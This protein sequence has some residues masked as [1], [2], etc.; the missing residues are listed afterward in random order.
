MSS[1]PLFRCP[2]ECGGTTK[3]EDYCPSC[4]RGT[5]EIEVVVA[6]DA[7]CHSPVERKMSWCW[8]WYGPEDHRMRCRL[9]KEHANDHDCREAND[10]HKHYAI[11]SNDGK[12]IT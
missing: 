12:R 1:N 2:H 3:S 9:P 5:F 7:E 11:I 10:P 6:E 8:V 4:R